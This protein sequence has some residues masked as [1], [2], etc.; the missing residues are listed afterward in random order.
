MISK[1][2]TSRGDNLVAFGDD[3]KFL[4]FR[5]AAENSFDVL[6]LIICLSY[7][8]ARVSGNLKN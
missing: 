5:Y 1:E 7:Q 8:E 4:Y 2:M 6:T 3:V